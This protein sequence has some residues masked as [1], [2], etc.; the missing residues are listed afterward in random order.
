MRRSC[1]FLCFA[2][3]TAD[4]LAYEPAVAATGPPQWQL[5][6][7]HVATATLASVLFGY[8]MG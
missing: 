3:F 6:L 5:S 4:Y 1:F 2:K 7:P 8:H